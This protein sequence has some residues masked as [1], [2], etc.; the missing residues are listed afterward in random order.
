MEAVPCRYVVILAFC[1][2][3]GCSTTLGQP[4]TQTSALSN[5]WVGVACSA[6]GSRVVAATRNYPTNGQIYISSDGGANW[7]VS[8]A[9]DLS[10]FSLVV[11]ADG[12]KLA[13][14]AAGFRI[15]T[16]ADAGL[17]W[18]LSRTSS[19]TAGTG[20]WQSLASSADGSTLATANY[21]GAIFL[22]TNVGSAWRSQTTPLFDVIRVA[23]SADG[24]RLL[25]A[26]NNGS[27]VASTNAGTS[28]SVMK[29]VPGPV[30]SLGASVD[31]QRVVVA[32]SWN[33]STPAWIV[34]ST[35]MGRTWR[36]NNLPGVNWT[37]VAS[38]ADGSHFVGVASNGRI[39]SSSDSGATWS[40][41]SAPALAWQ[42]VASSAD[43]NVLFA[44]ATNGG[45]WMRRTGAAPRLGITRT[46]NGLRASW[47]VPSAALKL[48][49]TALLTPAV[50]SDVTNTPT[51]NTSNLN[52]ELLLSTPGD[53]TFY[54]LRD[55]N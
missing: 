24:V 35:D 31:L 48:Q 20:G 33:G 21:T 54:R 6:D 32:A 44:A 34:T 18:I 19:S 23:C 15:Y 4:W 55:V 53:N 26:N 27:L 52:S 1:S 9:P 5:S 29:P 47:L 46:G 2:I 14:L 50:W 13:A 25:A 10:W 17:T 43:G 22:S 28:W 49:Q 39:Y 51:L 45:I 37:A 30:M 42:A 11:S 3:C 38:S 12:T 41:N 16:S 36:T 7:T 8:S 40:S